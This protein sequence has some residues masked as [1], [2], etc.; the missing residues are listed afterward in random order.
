MNIIRRNKL[1]HKDNSLG[2]LPIVR[3]S[4]NTPFGA[5]RKF[6][7][8][9][10][11]VPSI[12]LDAT[13]EEKTAVEGEGSGDLISRRGLAGRACKLGNLISG[14]TPRRIDPKTLSRDFRLT[15]QLPRSLLITSGLSSYYSDYGLAFRFENSVVDEKMKASR[16]VQ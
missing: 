5:T 11:R 15:F 7:R 2:R 8:D 4:L 3:N 16:I 6:H 9:N 14:K 12:F 10:G 13:S 1:V